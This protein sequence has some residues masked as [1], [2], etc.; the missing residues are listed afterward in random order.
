MQTQ[1]KK[2]RYTVHKGLGDTYRQM[3]PIT[4]E[5]ENFN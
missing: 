4:K 1:E 3:A 2:Y 5:R